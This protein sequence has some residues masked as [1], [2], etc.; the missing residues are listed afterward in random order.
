MSTESPGAGARPA[1]SVGSGRTADARSE[2]HTGASSPPSGAVLRK[3]LQLV[4]DDLGFETASLF[5]RGPDGWKLLERQGPERAWHG[6]LDPSALEGTEEAAEYPDA[7]TIPGI[8]PRLAALGCA[9]VASL[10]LP[11][12]G[13]LLVDSSTPCR[14]GGWIE[15][16]RPYLALISL[17]AGPALPAGGALRS[18]EEVA[19]LRRVFAACQDA[20][21]HQ[22]AG[23]EDL[24]HDVRDAIRADELYLMVEHGGGI[25]VIPSPPRERIPDVSLELRGSL[26]LQAGSALDTET[27]GDLAAAVGAASRALSAAFGREK[28]GVELL[29]AGWAAGPALSDVSMTVVARAV[30]TARSAMVSRKRAVTRL[31]H[32]ERSRIAYALHD[33]LTQT[34]AGA[35][36]ELE[37][38]RARVERDPAEAIATLENSKT[39][40]RRALGEL[41]ALLFD[42]SREPDEADDEAAPL[43]RYV[44]D[45]VKRWKLPA[46]VSMEGDL[47]AVPPR[48]LSVA[49]IVIRE[50]LTNAAKHAPG[51]NVSVD[52]AAGPSELTV[53]VNDAGHGFT[54][55]EELA[56]REGR[57]FG[58][59]M[60]HQR[61]EE[62]GG[63]LEVHSVRGSGTRITARLPFHEVAS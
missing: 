9:S 57:H 5:V 3:D 39:E 62:I 51:A 17:M 59:H 27:T 58:L 13:R 61:V 53:S 24:V 7:R 8:G 46:R 11:D 37:A 55:Q 21:G 20:V 56:A 43:A 31:V 26:V 15:R 19:S 52:L 63:T 42:L 47:H 16:S 44:D 60:L 28:D 1:K 22:G 38:L 36:L 25:D 32:R 18:H 33:G 40:I 34:V 14:S 6:V 29:L 49:Y 50:A 45:V 41:R 54:P 2:A 12:G 10:P 23:L 4:R 30:S 35:I 48:V